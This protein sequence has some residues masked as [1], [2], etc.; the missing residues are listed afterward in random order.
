[1]VLRCASADGG[2]VVYR[3]ERSL[4]EKVGEKRCAFRR[5]DRPVEEG[6]RCGLVDGVKTGPVDAGP[7]ARVVYM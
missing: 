6:R 2:W 3:R 4:L 7:A 5:W 1:M